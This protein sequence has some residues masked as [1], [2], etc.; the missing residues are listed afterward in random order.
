MIHPCDGQIERQQT[1]GWAIAYTRYSIYAVAR[2][3]MTIISKMVGDKDSVTIER[4]QEMAH[5]ESN[6]HVT[7]DVT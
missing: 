5:E 2:N 4:L 1:D 3:K 6:G 7:D